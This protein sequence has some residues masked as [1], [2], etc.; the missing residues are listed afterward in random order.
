MITWIPDGE[1]NKFALIA[2]FLK[3]VVA[4][5]EAAYSKVGAFCRGF[6]TDFVVENGCIGNILIAQMNGAAGDA[7]EF[8]VGCDDL[9]GA[10]YQQDAA[11][12]SGKKSMMSAHW[13]SML[14]N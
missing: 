1:Q 3:S 4:L 13:S 11:D 9:Y 10:D 8:L 12:K 14:S 6:D 5:T 7:I 2:K